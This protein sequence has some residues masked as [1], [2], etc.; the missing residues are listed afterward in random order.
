MSLWSLILDATWF[1]RGV[2]LL[3]ALFSLASWAIIL[4]R[5]FFYRARA[6]ASRAFERVR[7]RATDFSGLLQLAVSHG[8]AA[9]ARS[10]LEA[11]KGL[12]SLPDA[13]TPDWEVQLSAAQQ[14][15]DSEQ[16]AWLSFLATVSSA[17][18]FIG[19]L[20]TVWGV[21]VAFF[22]IGTEQG[23]AML[24]IVG[25]GIAEALIATVIGLATAIP[26]TIAYNL[27]LARARRMGEAQRAF[28]DQALLLRRHR[29]GS[30]A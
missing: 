25:P 19:L 14:R 22:R 4:E 11:G 5:A 6:A 18:P 17:S 29:P 10:L 26:A 1:N 9:E 2:L 20:G 8:N 7:G 12:A 30:V 24:E 23:Q 21:M 27:Y 13:G 15:R 3:L 16:Q 28:L